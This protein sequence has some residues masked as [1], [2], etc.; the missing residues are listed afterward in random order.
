MA[1]YFK[2]NRF[3]LFIP[4]VMFLAVACNNKADEKATERKDTTADTTTSASQASQPTPAITGI[5]L[6]GL[7]TEATSF[8]NL[9]NK[10]V[11]FALTFINPDIKTLSGWPTSNGSYSNNPE[12][13]L[14]KGSASVVLNQDTAFVGNVMIDQNEV[15]RVKDTIAK[16][17]ATY[18]L[19]TPRSSPEPKYRNHIVYDI[20]VTQDN[21]ALVKTPQATT[22]EVIAN[23]SPP[24]QL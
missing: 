11:V 2:S 4:V 22:T 12:I 6:D 15:K 1:T 3:S 18:V 8:N 20:S 5:T 14:K 23:P 7:Y 16:Y 13:Q 17:N 19:F 10:K 21:P 9:P 24:K